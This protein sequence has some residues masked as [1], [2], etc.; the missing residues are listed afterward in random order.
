MKNLFNILFAVLFALPVFTACNTDNGSNPVLNEPDTFVLNTPA[1][2][3][4]NV[5]DLKN[6]ST[7]ELACSQPD[8][9]FPASTTYTVQVS[10]EANFK[11][12][13]ADAKANY[14]ALESTYTTAKMNVVASELN[15]ALL[16]L[17]TAAKGEA[18]AFPT[19]PISVYV[20]LKAAITDSGRGVCY[21][22]VIN[23]PKVLG[24]KEAS[25][26]A[27]P[28]T[29]FVVGSMLNNWGLWKPM[30]AVT[31]LDGQFWTMIYFDANSEFKFGTKQNEYIGV[32][33]KRLTITDKANAGVAGDD[34]IKVTT[35][36]WYI[37]YVKATVKNNDYAFAMT[38]YPGEVY[39]FGNST[40]GSW[41]YTDTWKFTAPNAKDGNFVSPAMTAS[42]E[43]RMCVKTEV[44]WWRTE[45][46][47]YK[48]EI[49][50]R[51][52]QAINDSWNADKGSDYSIQG[53]AG[54]VMQ[55]NFTAGT[56][57][58]K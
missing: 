51:E 18:T 22:N 34:N 14:V 45:F 58:I 15:S 39:L 11:D 1:Y 55:L 9:G 6:A 46:T 57:E 50:Y 54:K 27:P 2:A 5:Y 40:G 16:D 38:F 53:A 19:D 56:G 36:G 20:R 26:L 25:S 12:A 29:L 33:D 42:G 10:L 41:A 7:L 37:V 49:F 48:G 47:L 31:G 17:W 32:T 28:K 44:D 23:L 30:V 35:A 21:S 13:T 24:T 52:N 3:A 8:Y 43:V 4:N